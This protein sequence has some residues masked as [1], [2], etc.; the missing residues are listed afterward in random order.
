MR[1]NIL[2]LSYPF[3]VGIL[4]GWLQTGLFFQLTF[5]FSSG[6]TTYL[7]ITLC[8]LA[9]SALGV[10]YLYRLPIPLNIFLLVMIGVY[11]LIS[12]LV[13]GFPYQ[14]QMRIIYGVLIFCTGFYPGV[15]FARLSRVY[16][17]RQMFFW[18]NNGFILGLIFCTILF[19]VYGGIMLWLIPCLIASILYIWYCDDVVAGKVVDNVAK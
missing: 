7:L 15:F 2:N 18:E 12:W 8:W 19:M 9:G 1:K 11:L 16:T 10:Y 6:F 17:T 5:T 4:L 3:L 14:S 13:K